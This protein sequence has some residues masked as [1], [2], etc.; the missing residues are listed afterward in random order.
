MARH[1]VTY[2]DIA[3]AADEL[4]GQ[5]KNVT[6]ENVRAILGTG[7]IGTINAHLRKWKEAQNPLHQVL[8]KEYPPEELLSLLKSLW[9]RVITQSNEEFIPVEEKFQRE[10]TELEQELDKYKNN[11]K[12][13]QKLFTHWQQENAKITQ[14]KI[15][16]EQALDFSHKENVSL[17][18]KQDFLYQQLQEKNERINELHHLHKQ[19]KEAAREQRLLDQQQHEQQTQQLQA[20]IKELHLQ[21]TLQCEKF[22]RLDKDYQ[23]LEKENAK[24]QLHLDEVKL[25]LNEVEK[26][27]DKNFHASQHWQHQYKEIQNALKDQMDHLIDKKSENKL[28]LQ[29]LQ[30]VENNFITLQNQFKLLEQEKWELT[31]EKA[32]LEGRLLE[33]QI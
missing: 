10:I 31:K 27:S 32:K 29:Q 8:P 1:G 16:L 7:S 11:N 9:D 20:Q 23:T 13:W 25:K 24:A 22:I 4:K 12:R 3:T 18:T 33:M 21:L 17:Q 5:G 19:D 28:L 30:D 6:I 26:M 2:Q 15:T 14:E